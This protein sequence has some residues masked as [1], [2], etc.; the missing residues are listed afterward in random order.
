MV[1]FF[2]IFKI[3]F[4]AELQTFVESAVQYFTSLPKH[5]LSACRYARLIAAIKID[6]FL[7]SDGL[8]V[9]PRPQSLEYVIE[10]CPARP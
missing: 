3:S 9:K 4:N 10:G 8:R 2:R 7:A 5:L 1:Y 6:I